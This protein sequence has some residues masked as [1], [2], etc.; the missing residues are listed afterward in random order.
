MSK[1]VQVSAIVPV[2]DRHSPL[3][4]LYAEYKAG[5]A[6]LGSPYELIFVLDGPKPKYE[7]ALAALAA[8]GEPITVVSLT[9][10]FGEATAIMVGFEQATGETIV[11]L[12]AYLQV[13]G[14]EVQALCA[15]LGTADIAVGRR[16]PR[17]S[18]WFETLRRGAF[19]RLLQFVT[20]LSFHDL[21]CNA[22]AMQRKVLEEIHLYGDQ[23]RFLPVLAERQGF[24][25]A[26]VAVRQSSN[27]RNERAYPPRNYMRSFL[28][29]FTVFF[30][31]RFTKKPLRFFG[32]IGVVTL[33]VGILELLYLVFERIVFGM[34]LADRP[35]LLLASLLIVLG[36]Q[37]FALGLLGELII[38]THAGGN[39]D[40]QVDRVVQ[41]PEASA[42]AAKST[43]VAN[44]V[45]VV[46]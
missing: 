45:K 8:E 6:G 16:E 32:M 25:V 36:V 24:R 37:I 33:G 13:E 3:P 21:G 11:T 43:S 17:A 38:F 23:Q 35:A 14:R 30:L 41:Y 19:H 20:R 34:P 22:R 18:R 2:G 15:A 31:V 5:L 29:I 28:D 42:G 12:P 26:E 40:Y 39:K 44:A 27:D 7:K 46:A 9:R 1:K 4:E 10:Y